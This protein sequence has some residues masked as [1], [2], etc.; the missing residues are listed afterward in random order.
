MLWVLLLLPA[1]IAG[2]CDATDPADITAAAAD[3][4]MTG[5]APLCSGVEDMPD[6]TVST[7][8]VTLAVKMSKSP[9]VSLF[10]LTL[11]AV[12]FPGLWLSH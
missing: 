6:Y 9:D 10:S 4:P 12:S 8:A 7:G 2:T 3:S 11:A 5:E 1:V